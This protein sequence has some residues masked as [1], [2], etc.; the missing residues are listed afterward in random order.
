MARSAAERAQQIA[1]DLD[2]YLSDRERRPG[3]G[4][5]DGLAGPDG[6]YSAVDD[7]AEMEAL[8]PVAP[9]RPRRTDVGLPCPQPTDWLH[10]RLTV[11]GAP[12]VVAAFRTTAAGAGIVPWR[13][14]GERIEEDLF[15]RMA[16]AT[17]RT[18]SLEGARILAAQLRAAMERRH[19]RA[20]ARVGHS[21]ACP[22]DLHALVPVQDAVLQ[23]GPDHPDAL[24]WLWEHWGTTEALRHV[25]D[26][27][28]RR[29]A[30]VEAGRLRLSFWSADWT[31]WRALARIGAS[32]PGLRFAVRPSY[33]E[34]G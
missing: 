22:F 24:A 11:T 15:L 34:L 9:A 1:A 13:L 7:R 8:A 12:A 33:D 28:E 5:N 32:W 26:E 19:Q 27:D 31:P 10:H 20:V 3:S 16:T 23:L 2:F 30:P 18:I 21:R 25:R 4:G 6:R 29:S 17:P 14:D